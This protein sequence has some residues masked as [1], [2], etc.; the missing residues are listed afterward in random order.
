[1]ENGVTDLRR[2]P[3]KEDDWQF[4]IFIISERPTPMLAVVVHSAHGSGIGLPV[5]ARHEYRAWERNKWAAGAAAR[6]WRGKLKP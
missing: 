4:W 5:F 1:M 6:W 3:N 2:H